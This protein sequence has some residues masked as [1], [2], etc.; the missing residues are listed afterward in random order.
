MYTTRVK[1]HC[2]STSVF[3]SHYH[4]I[5][6]VSMQCFLNVWSVGS[7]SNHGRSGR[8][9]LYCFCRVPSK[10]RY[11]IIMCVCIIFAFALLQV[12][13]CG[14]MYISPGNSEMWRKRYFIL[15]KEFLF[16]SKSEQVYVTN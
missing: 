8:V 9:F 5:H 11:V 2:S 7:T 12:Y 13:S 16:Y 15:T 10:R 3:I 4:N 1:Q 14:F 6:Q